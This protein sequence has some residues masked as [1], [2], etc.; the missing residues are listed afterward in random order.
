MRR[1]PVVRRL[2]LLSRRLQILLALAVV[3]ATVSA[4][5]ASGASFVSASSFGLSATTT[6][7]SGDKMSIYDGNNQSAVNGTELPDALQVQIVDANNKPVSDLTVTF[8]VVTGGG[9]IV[10]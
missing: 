6:A 8:A 9:S 2:R 7:L 5:V 10:G 3:A 4:V 1:L